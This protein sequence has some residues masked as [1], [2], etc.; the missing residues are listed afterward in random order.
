MSGKG[1][2]DGQFLRVFSL[3]RFLAE[4]GKNGATLQKIHEA[5]YGDDDFKSGAFRKKFLRDRTTL[6]EI[7]IDVDN[8]SSEPDMTVVKNKGRYCIKGAHS[9]LMPMK[10]K[11]EEVLALVTG[12]KL[13]GH[14]V[15]PLDSSADSLWE[16]LKNQL[17][18][19]SMRKGERLGDAISLA[20]PVSDMKKGDEIF[21]KVVQAID[22]KKVLK[23]RQYENAAGEKISCNISPCALY[24]KYHAWY[25]LGRSPEELRDHIER[26]WHATNRRKDYKIKLRITGPQALDVIETEFFRGEKKE[27]DP[28]GKRGEVLYEVTLQGLERITLW[29]MR[30]LECFEIIGPKELRDEIDRR[31]NKYLE[32]RKMMKG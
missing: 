25:L 12:V 21:Q 10:I 15:K 29:I 6:K 20:M 24:F 1:S 22:E 27:L 31:V 2:C 5:V 32:H 19:D 11:D 18:A 26:D 7:Y 3:A 16:K 28:K 4:Q 9:F 8:D 14:F 17:P 23:V 13:A 30:S